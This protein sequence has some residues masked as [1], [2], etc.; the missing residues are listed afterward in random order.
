MILQ[1][2]RGSKF[3]DQHCKSARISLALSIPPIIV[4]NYNNN[5]WFLWCNLS[6][7][8]INHL[9]KIGIK[10]NIYWRKMNI[11]LVHQFCY[12][13]IHRMSSNICLLALC[14]STHI[15][16]TISVQWQPVR[17]RWEWVWLQKC[18]GTLRCV[19]IAFKCGSENCSQSFHCL[20]G[21][22]NCLYNSISVFK[23][24]IRLIFILLRA[25]CNGYAL[26]SRDSCSKF[27]SVDLCSRLRFV[28]VFISF[29]G[30]SM[31]IP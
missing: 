7:I 15:V 13:N 30:T 17:S 21:L 12:N 9:F 11:K 27:W 28:V 26:Y 20:K 25:D 16:C 22:N 4:N 10:C 14:P 8:W 6:W 24:M 23:Y 1:D 18:W 19:S 5:I 2:S 29:P 3:T 31:E